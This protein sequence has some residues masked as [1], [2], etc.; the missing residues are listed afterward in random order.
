MH[1]HEQD[2]IVK[3][4]PPVYPI[5]LTSLPE[6]VIKDLSELLPSTVEEMKKNNVVLGVVTWDNLKKVYKWRDYAPDLF[7]VGAFFST[8]LNMI[9]LIYVKKS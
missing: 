8:Q 4:G 9:Y 5:D 7:L 1:L 3:K 2:E 6:A